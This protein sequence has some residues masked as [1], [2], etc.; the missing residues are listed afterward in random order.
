MAFGRKS[1]YHRGHQSL[2]VA[3][4]S[5]DKMT[6]ANL[7]MLYDFAKAFDRVEHEKLIKTL[8]KRGVIPKFIHLIIGTHNMQVRIHEAR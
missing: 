3:T 1:A 5:T 8:E 2:K 4:G 7:F 6:N